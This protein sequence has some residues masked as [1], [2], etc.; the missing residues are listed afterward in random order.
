[1]SWVGRIVAVS[2]LEKPYETGQPIGGQEARAELSCDRR[3]RAR[4]VDQ[5]AG[6]HLAAIREREAPAILPVHVDH[7][8]FD[9]VHSSALRFSAVGTPGEA[10]EFLRG[11][12]A[13]YGIDEI[14]L[15]GYAH[16]PAMRERSYRLMAEEWAKDASAPAA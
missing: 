6:S 4:G 10:A 3:G 8:R 16:D 15:T 11:F 5:E 13:S 1:M 7:P 2:I 12:A 9:A 14:I